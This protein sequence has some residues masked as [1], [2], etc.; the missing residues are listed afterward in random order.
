L[1]KS[2]EQRQNFDIN[3]ESLVPLL[4][5][6]GVL[7][8]GTEDKVAFIGSYYDRD[9]QYGGL[10]I[11]PS[12]GDVKYFPISL[13][14]IEPIGFTDSYIF[15]FEEVEYVIRKILTSD[16]EWMSIY[17]TELPLEVL[18]RF[19]ISSSSDTISKLIGS[20]SVESLPEF[21]SLYAYY[22]E[23]TSAVISLVYLSS[24]GIY[25]RTDGFWSLE[26]ISLPSY[27]YLSTIEISPDTAD[28]FIYKFD[29]S[30][31]KISIEE[32]MKYEAD[33][34]EEG[35]SVE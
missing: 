31:G 23:K 25:S 15:V 13:D 33:D 21:E 2:V 8:V 16:G 32:T 7:E 20:E 11:I 29:E 28:E 12:V 6:V 14:N 9:P 26:D 10:Y 4:G 1:E 27:Q 35:E 5:T 22:D 3:S 17:K 34:A 18:T 19:V 30:M 24:Y